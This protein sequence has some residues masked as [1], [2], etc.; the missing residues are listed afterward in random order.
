MGA[1]DPSHE[2]DAYRRE[3]SDPVAAALGSAS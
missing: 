1:A 2:L 3:I